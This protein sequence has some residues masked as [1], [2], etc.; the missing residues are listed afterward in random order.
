MDITGFGEGSVAMLLA[1]RLGP[2][3]IQR[4]P[5]WDAAD[6]WC[7][8]RTQYLKWLAIPLER[9]GLGFGS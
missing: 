5:R 9:L 2:A 7:V 4:V 1:Y 6:S 8:R 3:A